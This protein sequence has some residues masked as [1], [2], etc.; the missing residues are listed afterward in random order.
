MATCLDR[1]TVIIRPLK[2]IFVRYN[3]VSTQ[4]DPIS[5]TVKVKIA[6][7]ELLFEVKGKAVPL[8]ACRGQEGS[9]K[10]RF[11][12]FVTAQNGGKV[13]SLTHRPPLPAGNAP[14]IHFC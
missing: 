6:Y 12:D 14:S 11:P 10:L 3:K 2:N 13:F 9:R 5:F 8:Q 7:D 1:K 4:W